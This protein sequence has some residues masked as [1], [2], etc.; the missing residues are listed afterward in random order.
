MYAVWAMGRRGRRVFKFGPVEVEP[1]LSSVDEETMH[2]MRLFRSRLVGAVI[3][4]LAMAWGTSSAEANLCQATVS[5]FILNP[6]SVIEGSGPAQGDFG[7]FKV[8]NNSTCDFS[9]VAIGMPTFQD[10]GVDQAPVDIITGVDLIFDNCAGGLM[11]G[12]SC[13]F[14]V[15]FTTGDDNN[16][17]VRANDHDHGTFQIRVPVKPTGGSS[18]DA[19]W[20]INI[21]DTPEPPTLLLLTSALVTLGVWKRVVSVAPR[22]L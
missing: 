6:S 11:K 14:V 4:T 12:Q 8:K 21:N 13:G 7:G 3:V 5:P 15:A 18:P 19:V 1:R 16:G 22:V 9:A 10:L 20:N 17:D 2:C